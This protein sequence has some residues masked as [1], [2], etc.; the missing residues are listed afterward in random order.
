[1]GFSGA[2]E[3][4]WGM[5]NTISYALGNLGYHLRPLKNVSSLKGTDRNILKKSLK[6]LTSDIV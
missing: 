6:L 3:S 5:F 1:M 2:V 4:S